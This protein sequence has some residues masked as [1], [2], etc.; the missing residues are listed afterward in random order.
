MSQVPTVNRKVRVIADW[1]LALLFR[2]EVVSLGALHTPR[3]AFAR[4]RP[5]LP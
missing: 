5:P 3:A 2:R 4:S 1:T